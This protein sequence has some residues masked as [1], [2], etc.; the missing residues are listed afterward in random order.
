MVDR[1]VSEPALTPE[2]RSSLLLHAFNQIQVPLCAQLTDQRSTVTRETIVTL[3]HLAQSY[4]QEF[5]VY[6]GRYF[7]GQDDFLKL[8]NNGKR[9]ISDMAHEGITQILNS[10]CIPK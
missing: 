8:L 6:S 9:L 2:E 3:V 5:A 10:I 7:S 4:P 1:A